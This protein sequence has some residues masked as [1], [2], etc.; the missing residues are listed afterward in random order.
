MIPKFRGDSNSVPAMAWLTEFGR[1][2]KFVVR[3]YIL[4][5]KAK[6]RDLPS[7]ESFENYI[8]DK[9]TLGYGVL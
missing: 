5:T 9:E 7:P 6:A 4:S 8:N 1:P 2:L 3:T